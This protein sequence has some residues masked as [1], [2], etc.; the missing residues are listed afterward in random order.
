MKYREVRKDSVFLKEM[1]AMRGKIFLFLVAE[2][3]RYFIYHQLKM[4]GFVVWRWANRWME[5]IEQNLKW[6]NEKKLKYHETILDGL[7]KA[8]EALI[9]LIKGKYKGKVVV[10]V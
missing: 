10:K 6:L 5:G 2:L 8:P 3:N 4:E 1:H 9:D 7:E